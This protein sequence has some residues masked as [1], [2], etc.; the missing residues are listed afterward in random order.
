MGKF[1][2]FFTDKYHEYGMKISWKKHENP[3]DIQ[4]TLQGPWKNSNK[5]KT[6]ESAMK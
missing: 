5:Q 1:H 4:R 6:Q 2:G 3:L